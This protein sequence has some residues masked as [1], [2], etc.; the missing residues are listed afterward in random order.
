MRIPRKGMIAV[1]LLAAL[2]T[3]AWAAGNYSTYPIVGQ[4]SFCASGNPSGPGV[5]GVTGQSGIP[6]T[7]VQTVPAG[8]P[9]QTGTETVP[10]DTNVGSNVNPETVTIPSALLGSLNAHQNYIMGGDFG[11]NLWQRGTTFSAITPATYQMIADR[12]FA[13]SASNTMTITQ[14]TPSTSAADYIGNVGFYSWMRV[15]RPSATPSGSSCVGQILDQKQAADLIGHNGVLSFYGY[16]PTTFSATN[17]A[18]QVSV[19]Y[20]TAADSATPGTNTAT[21]ALSVSGQSS[22]ITGYQANVVSGVGLTNAVISSGVATI[23]LTTTPTLYAVYAPIPAQNS[24]GTEVN[25][26]IVSFCATPTAT[27]TESTD[28]FEI[29]AVQLQAMPSAATNNMPNGVI[30]YTG[31]QRV[32]PVDEAKRELSYSYVFGDG[33]TA[34]HGIFGTG[35]DISTSEAN[36]TVPFPV[37]MRE[38]PSVTVATATSFAVFELNGTTTQACTTLA[39]IAN[40]SLTTNAAALNCTTGGTNLT[41]D[42]G[43]QLTSDATGAANTVTFLAEP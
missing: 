3:V 7:C 2:S 32:L 11:T 37:P 38:S 33:G 17:E 6:N 20:Y 8:P 10:A 25:G 40:S 43:T 39:K 30:G 41:A 35:W 34:G 27:S 28:Y 23:D 4:P 16:A 9:M 31:F 29:E 22:G 1:G 18:I 14:N 19:A 13:V 12:W 26:V 42:A 21:A 15:A 5:G 36:V 24:S